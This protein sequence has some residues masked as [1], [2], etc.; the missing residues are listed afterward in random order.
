MRTVNDMNIGKIGLSTFD[1]TLA[2]A[3]ML[4]T[5]SVANAVPTIDFDVDGSG[6]SASVHNIAGSCVRCCAPITRASGPG[7]EI[8][9]LAQGE[10]Y[11]FDFSIDSGS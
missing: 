6:S 9:P 7:S 5:A 1:S 11:T 3:V 10:S 4:C 2:G 8:F